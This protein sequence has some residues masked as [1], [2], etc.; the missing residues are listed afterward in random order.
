MSLRTYYPPSIH[1]S[2]HIIHSTD[3]YHVPIPGDAA[4][5]KTQK[6]LS[7]KAYVLVQEGRQ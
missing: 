6:S 1:H 7:W 2:E 3:I 5:N 4:A